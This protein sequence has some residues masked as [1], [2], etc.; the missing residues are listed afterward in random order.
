MLVLSQDK[1][2]ARLVWQLAEAAYSSPTSCKRPRSR[3]ATGVRGEAA[4]LQTRLWNLDLV[5]GRRGFVIGKCID[6]FKV[7][8]QSM[9]SH[10]WKAF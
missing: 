9:T 6:G 2:A 1:G 5:G 4:I 10:I 7:A 3:R 8:E